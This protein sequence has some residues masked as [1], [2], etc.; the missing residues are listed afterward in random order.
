MITAYNTSRFHEVVREDLERVI[1]VDLKGT[2][3]P[4]QGSIPLMIKNR[5]QWRKSKTAE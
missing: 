4:S 3:R 1:G 2:F 5:R